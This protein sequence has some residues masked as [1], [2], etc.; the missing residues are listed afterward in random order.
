MCL[1]CGVVKETALHFNRQHFGHIIECDTVEV[2]SRQIM[3]HI[4]G[5][6]YPVIVYANPASVEVRILND[7]SCKDIRNNELASLVY[8][9]DFYMRINNVLYGHNINIEKIGNWINQNCPEIAPYVVLTEG[10][11]CVTITV[12][13]EIQ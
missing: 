2:F 8:T 4:I 5:M 12:N 10:E 9:Q 3:W 7:V 6:G 13:G 1:T 11:S